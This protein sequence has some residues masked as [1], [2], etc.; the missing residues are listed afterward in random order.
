[1][2]GEYPSAR[3]SSGRRTRGGRTEYAE[4]ADTESAAYPEPGLPGSAA[5]AGLTEFKEYVASATREEPEARA[6]Q[7][8]L[9]LL[10]LAPRTRAQLADALRQRGIPDDVAE[11]VLG[12]FAGAGLIDDAAFARAWVDS[13]HYGRGLS[14]R[15]LTA[16]LRQRG[17][18][19]DRIKEA[20][21]ELG[22][23]AEA[24]TARRLVE[25]KLAA[26]VGQAPE[27]RVRRLSGMLARKGYPPGLAFRVIREALEAEGME[28]GGIEAAGPE[29]LLGEEPPV[30]DLDP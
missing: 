20:V 27:A 26:T 16:E 6:R 23:D 10:T 9:R 25:R 17:V 15:A 7:V 21:D 19:E 13:R 11:D 12:R 22:P 24:Q 2:I 3:R 5:G 14:G 18:D 29:A 28:T 30:D 1:M 4:H 8:C